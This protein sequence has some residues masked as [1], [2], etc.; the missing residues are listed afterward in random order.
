MCVKADSGANIGAGKPS[1]RWIYCDL[2]LRGW[3]VNDGP[4]KAHNSGEEAG[5]LSC[6]SSSS[7]IGVTRDFGSGGL[8]RKDGGWRTGRG[9]F[10]FRN[11]D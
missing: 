8:P 6:T 10:E 11:T 5:G 7:L 4:A 2:R 3:Q 9:C 1:Q